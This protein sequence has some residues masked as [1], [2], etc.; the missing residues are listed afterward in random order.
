VAAKDDKYT[1][2]VGL[3]NFYGYYSLKIGLI[4][5]GKVIASLPILVFFIFFPETVNRG[6]NIGGLKE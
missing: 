5:A 4:M 2:P 1:L 6:N 3:T